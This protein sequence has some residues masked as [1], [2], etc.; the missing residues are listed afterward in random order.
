MGRFFCHNPF[1]HL[2]PCGSSARTAIAPRLPLN[3][4]RCRRVSFMPPILPPWMARLL[5][6]T[7][8][9]TRGLV[10]RASA[11]S[12]NRT[13]SLEPDVLGNGRSLF[14]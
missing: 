8:M 4:A 5:A 3:V 10:V 2:R 9:R 6:R 14:Q 12:A 1:L 13:N 11:S 7:H